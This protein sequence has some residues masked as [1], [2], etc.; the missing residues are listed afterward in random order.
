M[1]QPKET[2]G[3]R[4]SETTRL[5]AF[6][7]GIFAIVITLLV[8][9]LIPLLH[10]RDGSVFSTTN[11]LHWEPYFAFLIGFATVLICWINHHHIFDH[12]TKTDGKLM[13]INGF[14]M[15]LITIIPFTTA[16]LAELINS[17]A[18]TAF[19]IYGSNYILI[20]IASYMI[21]A[22]PLKKEF[23][24]AEHRNY[25]QAIKVLFGYSIIYTCIAFGVCFLSVPIAGVMY[26]LL[27]V[28]FAFPKFYAAKLMK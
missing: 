5:E 10:P 8:L 6:S 15:L 23:I 16:I 22:Y 9:E 19:A 7:D 2:P 14:V 25:V 12:I 13:W 3:I 26:I 24:E 21:T 4:L 11:L 18:R 1:N 27:F 20:S 28:V 17:D